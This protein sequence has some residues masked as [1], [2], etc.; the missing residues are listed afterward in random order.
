MKAR[1]SKFMK[2]RHRLRANADPEGIRYYEHE[3]RASPNY[4]ILH[5]ETAWSLTG[6][7]TGRSDL[8][9]TLKGEHAARE[10]RQRLRHL[11]FARQTYALSGWAA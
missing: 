3:Q 8:P 2:H 1:S 9:L 6:Q 5:G 10:N 7:H 11:N 4:L